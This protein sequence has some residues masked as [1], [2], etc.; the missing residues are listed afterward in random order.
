VITG[1]H[2]PGQS[3]RRQACIRW[4][5]VDERGI[6]TEV[7]ERLSDAVEQRERSAIG[8]AARTDCLPAPIDRWLTC[9]GI[10]YHYRVA[11]SAGTCGAPLVLVHGL[12]V[13]SAYWRRV[14]PLLAARRPVYAVDLPGFGRTTRPPAVLDS[15]GQAQALADWLAALGLPR[16][17]L[18]GHSAGGQVAASFAAAHPER[19]AGLILAASTIGR[20]SPKFLPHLPHLLRDLLRERP[21]L[22]PV[23]VADGLRAGPWFIL[24]TDAAIIQ[25][26]TLAAVSRVTAPLLVMRG[27]RDCII[28]AGETRRLLDAAPHASS[29]IIP[30]AAHV[31]QWSHPQAV[32]AAVNAFLDDTAAA[33]TAP[34]GR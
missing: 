31:P 28:S 34:D 4:T 19:V 7:D 8:A 27:T 11:E 29:V 20:D 25:D 1:D 12:G 26:E 15:I 24:R 17:H 30:G 10:R 2:P 5:A 6:T 32:A 16:V 23:L 22:L 21:S 33:F 18:M 14:Q 9:G 3:S 13:S